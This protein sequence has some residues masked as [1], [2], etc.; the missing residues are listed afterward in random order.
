[1]K[2]RVN[3]QILEDLCNHFMPYM[4]LLAASKIEPGDLYNRMCKSILNDIEIMMKRKLLTRPAMFTI[5]FKEHE[6]IAFMQFLGDV[7]IEPTQ[8]WRV[9]MRQQVIDQ[10]HKQ[11]V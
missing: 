5:S 11:L 4:L 10:L 8:F 1:M 9:N 6:A 2:L 7:G 3:R